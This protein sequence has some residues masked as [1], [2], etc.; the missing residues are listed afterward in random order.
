MHVI[1]AEIPA[2]LVLSVS[3]R[4]CVMSWV[5]TNTGL[6]DSC[7]FW[8]PFTPFTGFKDKSKGCWLLEIFVGRILVTVYGYALDRQV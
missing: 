2:F 3:L 6:V 1:I 8:S 5:N 4:N 7:I